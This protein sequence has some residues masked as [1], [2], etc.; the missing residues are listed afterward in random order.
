MA[1]TRAAPIPKN[2][3]LIA[4]FDDITIRRKWFSLKVIPLA[5]FAI[6]WDGFLVFWYSAAF[7][8]DETPLVMILFP[9]GHIAAGVGITYYVLAS[10]VNK[11]DITV[12]PQSIRV[13]T[14]PMKWL[15][16]KTISI[17]EIKQLYTTE[18]IRRH[19]N[20]VS[21]TYTVSVMTNENREKKLLGG[22]DTKAQAL[23]IEHEIEKIIGIE[24]S[25]VVGEVG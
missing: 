11:T 7:G 8:N 17:A 10:F 1:A 22:L 15:G 4:G 20:G 16:D 6:V 23:F 21:I 2:L 24:N 19:K 3:D 25:A 9:I 14:Y 18:K 13:R 5:I 12:S